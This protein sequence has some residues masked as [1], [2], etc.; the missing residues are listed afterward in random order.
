MRTKTSYILYSGVLI[1]L[2]VLA[3]SSVQS[4]G[5]RDGLLRIYFFNVGQG[6][7]IFIQAP[8]GNQVL[9]DGGPDGSV[10][11]RLQEVM[12]LHD[13]SIDAVI[14]SHPHSDH[15]AGLAD[16]FASYDVAAVVQGGE[17]YDSAT[18]KKWSAANE[19]E[20][21]REVEGRLGK[22]LDLGSGVVLTVI[23]PVESFSGATLKDPHEA[24]VTILLKYGEFELLLTGDMESDAEQLLI[25]AGAPLDVDVLKVGHHGSKTSTSASFLM[26]TSP[27]TAVISVGA[28]NTYGHPAPSVLGRLENFGI[29]Y[30]RTDTDGSIRLTTDGERYVMETY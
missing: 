24:N 21:V 18:F 11:E 20:G 30:Y 17:D 1:I 25:D 5:L 13:R 16:V 9:I 10:I 12:P 23:Y 4:A 28:K 3:F 22:T 19:Q 8:N 15:I 6:D 27:Q 14:A 26:A 2:I 29:K 7:A